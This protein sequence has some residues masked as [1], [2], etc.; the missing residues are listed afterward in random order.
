MSNFTND[1]CVLHRFIVVNKAF[2]NLVCFLPCLIKKILVL[3]TWCRVSKQSSRHIAYKSTAVYITWW[4]LVNINIYI[5]IYTQYREDWS[6]GGRLKSTRMCTCTVGVIYVSIW[7]TTDAGL[8][9]QMLHNWQNQKSFGENGGTS[10]HHGFILG[11]LHI[12]E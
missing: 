11:I 9:R 12:N 8:Y 4:M 10:S 6:Y 1:T 7:M 3:N 2:C 5:Y